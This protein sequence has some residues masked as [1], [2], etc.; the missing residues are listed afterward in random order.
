VLESHEFNSKLRNNITEVQKDT[1]ESARRTDSQIQA[2]TA[3]VQE[4]K[5]RGDKRLDVLQ[6]HVA[7]L[8]ATTAQNMNET[9]KSVNEC[10][11]RAFESSPI[12]ECFNVK[13]GEVRTS[14]ESWEVQMTDLEKET[15]REI[16]KINVQL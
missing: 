14:I 10:V 4:N 13:I 3:T 1:T 5:S 16:S 12:V 11:G 9:E 6:G 7:T 15:E 2:L 8:R